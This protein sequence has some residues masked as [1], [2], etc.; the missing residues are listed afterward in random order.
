MSSVRL[1]DPRQK[2]H[3][4]FCVCVCV[5][6]CIVLLIK[7]L[8]S[9]ICLSKTHCSCELN[10]LVYFYCLK[11]KKWVWQKTWG[12]GFRLSRWIFMAQI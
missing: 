2:I 12:S 1:T 5:C 7:R 3:P 10:L 9:S 6:V 4:D 11:R 8:T